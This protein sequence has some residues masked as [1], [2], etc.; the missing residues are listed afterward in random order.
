ML[1]PKMNFLA[2]AIDPWTGFE[3]QGSP[4]M[5]VFFNCGLGESSDAQPMDTEGWLY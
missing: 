5:W 3:L 4:C 2:F 1:A